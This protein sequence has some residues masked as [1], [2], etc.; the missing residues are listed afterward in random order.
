MVTGEPGAD[1]PRVQGPVVADPW[2]GAE[3][4]PIQPPGMGDVAVEGPLL[5]QSPVISRHVWVGIPVIVLNTF[6]S[7]TGQSKR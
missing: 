7:G 1:G 6:E 5:K 2:G 3:H 4:A